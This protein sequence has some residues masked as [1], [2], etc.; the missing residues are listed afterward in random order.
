MRW[1][2]NA[3]T[4]LIGSFALVAALVGVVGHLGVAG[5]EEV[6]RLLETTYRRDLIGL[7]AVKDANI[8]MVDI[9]RSARTMVNVNHREGIEK[10]RQRIET[11]GAQLQKSIV[12]AENTLSSTE[13]RALISRIKQVFP[14][15]FALVRDAVES[16]KAAKREALAMNLTKARAHAD[17]M[18][19]AMHQLSAHKLRQVEAQYQESEQEYKATRSRVLW[20]AAGAIVLAL[21]LGFVIAQWFA[22]ALIESSVIANEVASG[23][24]QL[25][26]AA[27]ELSSGAQEQAASLE[28]TAASLEQMSSTVKS[29]AENA[30]QASELAAGARDTAGNGGLAVGRAVEAMREINAASK[31]IAEIITTIDEI[32]FQTN[33]LALN[34][35]VEAAR[36]G[37]QGRG[38]AVVAAEVRNLAKRSATSA[39][40]I[41]RLIQDTVAKVENGSQL[42]T[43]SGETLAEIVASVKRVTDI[44]AEIAAASQEQSS[45]IEQVTRATAQMDHVTQA[46]ASQT[47]ELSATAETMAAQGTRLQEV[48]ARFKLVREDAGPEHGRGL[49]THQGRPAARKKRTTRS[50][51][52]PLAASSGRVERAAAEEEFSEFQ[53]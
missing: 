10:L 45:G 31:N 29:N 20:I 15:Y 12:E 16:A 53:H 37:E 5:I 13:G 21:V 51:S 17:V 33:L 2:T 27:E 9:G 6:N 46:Y 44:V 24:Q 25:A 1:L 50:S 49:R 47:E 34:A 39:K 42:V 35:A 36:A 38:F 30:R 3:R 48:V 43:Q 41:K 19:E 8:A 40:E 4:K 32:A 7:A 52:G 11:F 18:D 14:T 23:S 26:A 22:K 28:E